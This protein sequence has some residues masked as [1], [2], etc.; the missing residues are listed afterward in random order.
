MVRVGSATSANRTE[1][2]SYRNRRGVRASRVVGT[3][4]GHIEETHRATE[5]ADIDVSREELRSVGA[6]M[7]CKFGIRLIGRADTTTRDRWASVSQE[8]VVETVMCLVVIS[9]ES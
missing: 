9:S 6:D 7:L 3:L 5:L 1:L 4:L 2:F 8:V